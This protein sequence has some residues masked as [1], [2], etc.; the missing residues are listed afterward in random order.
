MPLG[1]Q[2]ALETWATY[3]FMRDSET[4]TC[5]GS[6]PG[7]SKLNGLE[8]ALQNIINQLGEQRVIQFCR[9]RVGVIL[10][11]K[12]SDAVIPANDESPPSHAHGEPPVHQLSFSWSS[13]SIRWTTRP[14]QRRRQAIAATEVA[15]LPS[16]MTASREVSSLTRLVIA[17]YGNAP[18]P[19]VNELA[20]RI[21]N[22]KSGEVGCN[23]VRPDSS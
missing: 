15:R 5:S 4:E 20:K 2:P 21:W 11:S 10:L 14:N 16:A 13:F 3:R 18:P 9:C 23:D 12:E 19:G 6:Y 17:M 7:F 8:I 22:C 1:S